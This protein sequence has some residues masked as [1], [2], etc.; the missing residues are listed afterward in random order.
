V[1]KKQ[2]DTKKGRK[3]GGKE[4]GKGGMEVREGGKEGRKKRGS[5][6]NIE[7]GMLLMGDLCGCLGVCVDGK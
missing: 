7:S 3:E 2:E 1:G 6:G 5:C 4:R